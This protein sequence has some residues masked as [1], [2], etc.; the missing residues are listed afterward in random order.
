MYIFKST[1]VNISHKLQ[2]TSCSLQNN[3]ILSMF[4]S[5]HKISKLN[6]AIQQFHFAVVAWEFKCMRLQYSLTILWNKH[7]EWFFQVNVFEQNML[8]CRRWTCTI[9]LSQRCI[10]LAEISLSW[11][12]VVLVV[13]KWFAWDIS[14]CVPAW[15]SVHKSGIASW[16]TPVQVHIAK[17]EE[18]K[19]GGGL[20][21]NE[22]SYSLLKSF[23]FPIPGNTPVSL[24]RFGWW[25]MKM[26]WPAIGHVLNAW[27]WSWWVSDDNMF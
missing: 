9:M 24:W 20:H 21:G 11:L 5:L 1:A 4:W 6:I 18:Q 14:Q 2:L 17:P 23:S 26:H 13:N 8:W 7:F 3:S 25:Q 19:N 15:V 27:P 12:P 16:T 10:H 22:A